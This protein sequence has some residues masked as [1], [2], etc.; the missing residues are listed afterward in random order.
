VTDRRQAWTA[1]QALVT[2]RL[3]DYRREVAAVSGLPFSR[4]R[5][6]RRLAPGPITHGALA[7]ALMTDRPAATV[8]VDDLCARGLA[9]RT[10]H[11]TDRRRKL[12]S[13]TEEGHR[14][15]ASVEAVVPPPP[16]GWA[17]V[18]PADL[19]VLLRV[20]RSVGGSR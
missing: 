5:A 18:A 8:T 1:L 19:E 11:P 16:P 15:A 7:E 4:A 20:V 14:V 9:V 17:E 12:V 10:P 3:D 13:L 6:L 2:D